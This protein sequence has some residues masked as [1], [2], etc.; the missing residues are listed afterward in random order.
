MTYYT[1]SII[2][3]CHIIDIPEYRMADHV[4]TYSI[5]RISN[6]PGWSVKAIESQNGTAHFLRLDVNAHERRMFC[7]SS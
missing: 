1:A 4:I 6:A 7:K 5:V 2:T 3:M